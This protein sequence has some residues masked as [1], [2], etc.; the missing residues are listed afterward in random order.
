MSQLWGEVNSCEAVTKFW[1]T[2]T[3]PLRF[4]ILPKRLGKKKKIHLGLVQQSNVLRKPVHLHCTNISLPLSGP[5]CLWL[6]SQDAP[7][8]LL[9]PPPHSDVV[10]SPSTINN[11]RLRRQPPSPCKRSRFGVHEVVES[12]LTSATVFSWLLLSPALLICSQGEPGCRHSRSRARFPLT[13]GAAHTAHPEGQR[14]TDRRDASAASG[15]RAERG[16]LPLSTVGSD[17]GLTLKP[18][19]FGPSSARRRHTMQQVF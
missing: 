8:L 13:T 3:K 6:P 17:E 1:F 16:L 9:S 10:Y 12:R 11:K 18:P 2:T 15:A 19:G 5:L 7:L 14:Q 4:N